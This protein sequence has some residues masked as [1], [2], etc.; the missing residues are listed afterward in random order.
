[1]TRNVP[2]SN[3][4]SVLHAASGMS[5]NEVA[6]AFDNLPTTLR[7]WVA[8]KSRAPLGAL[9]DMARLVETMQERADVIAQ[10][11]TERAGQLLENSNFTI[12]LPYPADDHEALDIGFPTVSAVRA[13]YGLCLAQLDNEVLSVVRFL[14]VAAPLEAAAAEAARLNSFATKSQPLARNSKKPPP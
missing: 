14:P 7:D 5:I 13:M 3:P 8:G 6:V 9:Q 4:F 12:E 11:I 10:T 1:L 2:I